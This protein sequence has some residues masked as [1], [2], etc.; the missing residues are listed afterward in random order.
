[1]SL[2]NGRERSVTTHL[3]QE[4]AYWIKEREAI[5]IKHDAGLPQPWTNDKILATYRFCNVQRENDRLTRWLDKNWR[6]PFSEHPNL[7]VAMV[8]A[9]MLNWPP[10]LDLIG[11]P[12]QWDDWYIRNSLESMEIQSRKGIK[13]W[14][15]AYVITTC[16]VAMDK[17]Q[18]VFETV[19][20]AVA[21]AG[22]APRTGDTLQAFWTRLRGIPGLGA[23]FLAAQVVA[24]LK[25]VEKNPLYVASD[26]WKWA[27][28]GPGSK[29]G[30]NR[31]FGLPVDTPQ[32]ELVWRHRL[33]E[34]IEEVAPQICPLVLHAQDWQNVMCEFD[35]YQ[36]AKTGEGR[37]KRH[38]SPE[39]AYA[40]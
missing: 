13:V 27:V 39:T 5:R 12:D 24:D 40:V 23:G 16:G 20:N 1:M 26:W 11:F 25:N 17:G 4:V 18:Y 9:R 38:Y 19:C 28:P 3:K 34:M 31:Y 10:T 6:I 36:R 32:N 21:R 33:E 30:I 14:G 15:S 29:R 2:C 35:K 22:V 7:T 8:L 37:P